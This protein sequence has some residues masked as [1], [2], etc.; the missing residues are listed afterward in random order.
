[1]EADLVS[2]ISAIDLD[3]RK[4]IAALQQKLEN[5]EMELKTYKTI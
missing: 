4:Q 5:A 1:M 2:Q 3:R